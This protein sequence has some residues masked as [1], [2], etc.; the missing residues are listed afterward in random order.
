MS[1]PGT[2]RQRTFH[3]LWMLEVMMGSEGVAVE[4]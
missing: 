3:R 4:K 2:E 1:G